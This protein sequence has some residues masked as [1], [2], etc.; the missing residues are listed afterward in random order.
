MVASIVTT[1]LPN[2]KKKTNYNDY[3]VYWIDFAIN[4]TF[5]EDESTEK[6]FKPY[7]IS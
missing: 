4:L 3:K 7:W 1:R 2:P 5:W 6:L